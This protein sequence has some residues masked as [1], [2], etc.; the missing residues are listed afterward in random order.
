[1]IALVLL[2]MTLCPASPA[3]CEDDAC[4]VSG[5]S[6]GAAVS[7]A[8]ICLTIA[9]C[10]RPEQGVARACSKHHVMRVGLGRRRAIESGQPR[11]AHPAREPVP[12]IGVLCILLP[13][14]SLRPGSACR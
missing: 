4:S 7:A 6:V 3:G 13:T 10:H 14:H 2:A 9:I 8:S 1:M 5:G 12:T 11:E